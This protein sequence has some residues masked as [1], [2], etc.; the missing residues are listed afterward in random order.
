MVG[1]PVASSFFSPIAPL[2][3]SNF[4]PTSHEFDFPQRVVNS[5]GNTLISGKSR[6]VKS[7]NL[8]RIDAITG[9]HAFRHSNA[10]ATKGLI[11]S[12]GFSCIFLVDEE[13]HLRI[14][15]ITGPNGVVWLFFLQMG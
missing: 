2:I 5:K 3:W 15:T 8:P 12:Q 1:S 7:Y 11:W 14:L 13:K 4:I 9:F 6:L 10:G